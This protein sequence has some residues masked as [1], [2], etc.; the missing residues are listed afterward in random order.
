M[1][2]IPH[3]LRGEV[4]KALNEQLEAGIIRP[5]KSEWAAPLQIVHKADGGI[6]LTVDYTA[7]NEVIQFDPYPM[8]VTKV[9]LMQLSK[10]NW[11]SKFDFLKAYHQFPNEENSIKY[12][13]FICEFGLFEYTSMPMGIATAAAWFQRCI[14]EELRISLIEEFSELSST[15]QSSTPQIWNNI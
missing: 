15:T 8:P 11:F 9:I 13:A 2:Q 14:E 1:R 10:S 3:N 7:L 4:K 6:R 12:T 5:S